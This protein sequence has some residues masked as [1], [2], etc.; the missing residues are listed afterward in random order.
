MMRLP[1]I[2]LI[3]CALVLA[4]CRNNA[5]TVALASLNRSA[6]LQFLCADIERT[7][8]NRFVL[9]AILPAGLC[10]GETVV[11]PELEPQ[12]LGAVT[13]IERGEVAV[14]NFTNG[15]ISNTNPTVPGVTAVTVDEQPTGI[16]ISPFAPTYTYLTSFS[17]KSI[18]AVPTEFII[19]G[20]TNL[21]TPES[22]RLDAG[23]TDL[24][25]HESAQST[26][27]TNEEGQVT[28]AEPTVDYRTLYAAIPELGV[29][30]QV[31]VIINPVT[32]EQFLGG[33]V[34][35]PLPTVGCPVDQV[36]APEPGGLDSDRP[37]SDGNDYNRICPQG[38]TA[39]ENDNP[40]YRVIKTVKTTRPCAEGPSMGPRPI[41]LTIDSG[42][43]Q[44]SASQT[45]T[46]DASDDVLLV[47]DA[48]QPLIHR[49]ALGPGGATPLEPIITGTP[50]R[51]I[52]VTPFVPASSADDD[53]AATER[54]LYAVSAIDGSI[55]VIDYT[56]DPES[57]PEEDKTF[58]A[59]LPLIAG[60]SARANEENVE[61]RNR[62]RFA[63]SNVR[64]IEVISPSY[65]LEDDTSGTGVRV[66]LDSICDPNDS[67]ARALAQ[68]ASN[69]RGV[70]L[71]VSLS[72]GTMFFLD[73]YDLNAPCRGGAC[74]LTE[75]GPDRLASIRRHRERFQFTPATETVVEI[76]GSPSFQ[77][78]A[79]PGKLDETTG[80]PISSDGPGLEF[81]NC[82]RE[83]SIDTDGTERVASSMIGVFPALATGS[84]DDALICASSQVWSTF[85]ER[86]DATWQGL[87]P[88]SEGGLG[89]FADENL[90][91]TEAG[92]WFQA[93]DVPLCRVGVLGPQ[94]ADAALVE[95]YL[96]DRLVITGELPPITRDDPA[97]QE[98]A[99]LRDE[100]DERQVWFPILRAFNQELEIGESPASSTLLDRVRACFPEFTEYQIHTRQ[101]YTV[102]GTTSGF[103]NRVIPDA[104]DECIL[105][106]SR[107]VD[108]PTADDPFL[109]V[110]SYLAGR[111]FASK[112]Y[113]NPLVS[114]QIGPFPPEAGEPIPNA[115]LLN[116]N[117]S[118]QFV[119]LGLDTG[120]GIS[121]LPASILF[122]P[123]QD[124]LYLV[125]LDAGI[126][127]IVFSPLNIVQTFQ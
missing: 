25:L 15:F 22:R 61:S 73:I 121:S 96:G 112:Q 14:V 50:T 16:Q 12:F 116:F 29:V 18:Q 99:D 83:T 37:V 100:L 82:P 9:Q 47:A 4:S 27:I 89:R 93:G 43:E 24:A 118:N 17:A 74:T 103:I 88:N 13:Q 55:L 26:L 20:T 106:P 45:G 21:A 62:A 86:W 75:T 76:D 10:D 41:A 125:D 56:E 123:Q 124:Q 64:A 120:A 65:E 46:G 95:S 30:A 97:C 28:G 94:P 59:V 42:K 113:I 101:A 49:F 60:V 70:F 115:T 107:P 109:D 39:R 92:N 8:G 126:R 111:A 105:D 117:V 7:S 6:K 67:N 122:A 78:N 36:P 11:A 80:R 54:Y 114:F 66:P 19:S 33:P 87:I 85:S 57:T 91:G 52:A 90:E 104:L 35:L 108:L 3:A 81:I 119:R 23:P 58:G 5:D 84:N 68:S 69:M 51:E 34:L 110:D 40:R 31:Q 2:S 77:F 38:D 72:N 32:G 1:V 63:F 71:A 79:A 48:N 53:Q 102:T 127:R 98:F 44:G